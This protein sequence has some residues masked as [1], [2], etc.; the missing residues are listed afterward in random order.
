MGC[1]NASTGNASS[2]LSMYAING[3]A[4][5]AAHHANSGECSPYRAATRGIVVQ[6]IV[7]A[8]V[9]SVSFSASTR[10]RNSRIDVLSSRG[11]V[12]L[13]HDGGSTKAAAPDTA[14][15]PRMPA[16]TRTADIFFIGEQPGRS[17]RPMLHR[18]EP[19]YD[20]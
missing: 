1:A 9:G 8:A 13:A 2:N 3:V 17:Q 6:R 10:F 19:V 4:R 7:K 15:T 5:E 12:T 20:A 18:V 16:S 11:V 14:G